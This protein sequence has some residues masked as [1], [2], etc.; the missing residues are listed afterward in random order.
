M[1]S[2]PHCNVEL[3]GAFIE[4]TTMGPPPPPYSESTSM[5]PDRICPV[6]GATMAGGAA[7]ADRACEA[8]AKPTA[9][10]AGAKPVWWELLAPC[11]GCCCC[12]E[13]WPG[14]AWDPNSIAIEPIMI[15]IQRI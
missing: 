2:Q 5:W 4:L 14:T 11:M 1:F 7:A 10:A 13:Y 9:V 3:L 8:V 12:V 15:R 6:V